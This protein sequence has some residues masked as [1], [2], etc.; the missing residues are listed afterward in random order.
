[1]L[2]AAMII[3][4]FLFAIPG[5]AGPSGK[6]VRFRRGSGS[7]LLPRAVATYHLADHYEGQDFIDKWTFYSNPDPTHGTVKYLTKS[8]AIAT[9]FDDSDEN[10][11]PLAFVDGGVFVMKVDDKTKLQPG[12]HRQSVR[13]T[14]PQ[15]YDS[16]LF[17][18]NFSAM[19]FG[20][21]VWPAY[22]SVGE[23]WP[24]HGEIDVVEGVSFNTQNQMTL[25]TGPGCSLNPNPAGG[26]SGK[27]LS[28]TSC[29][30]SGKDNSGCAIHDSDADASFGEGFNQ[31]GGGV[32]VH[33]W[34]DNGIKIWRFGH[35]DAPQDIIDRKP[36]PTKWP[37]PMAFFDNTQC[38][39][40]H[41]KQHQLVLN[42]ALCGDW[43]GSAYRTTGQ[44]TA[45]TCAEAVAN[46]ENFQNARWRV[47]SISV[48]QSQ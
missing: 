42:I 13:I 26:M 25:H 48:Y 12:T 36:D 24:N 20:C 39:G 21:S 14:S 2:F 43:A 41:F 8:E 3:F 11:G 15:R 4:L 22:W 27:A 19:P 46:P 37:K 35:H 40:D 29:A 16:G 34:D 45:G 1:M 38:S 9:H 23:D 30:S 5:M 47:N 17:V 7:S 10:R 44:C 6:A 31:A 32:F 28:H 33:L 18:A